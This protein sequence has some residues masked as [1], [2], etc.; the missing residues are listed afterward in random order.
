MLTRRNLFKFAATVGLSAL[1]L[2]SSRSAHAALSEVRQDH[3]PV[4]DGSSSERERLLLDI[5]WLEN[6]KDDLDCV[7]V[8]AYVASAFS[9]PCSAEINLIRGSSHC[10]FCREAGF[11]VG[12]ESFGCM[13]CE[14]EGSA[15][16]YYARAEG[17][18]H[19]VA[20][21][22]LD[23]LLEDG[24]LKGRRRENEHA[25]SMLLEAEQ[26][27]HELLC[28]SPEGEMARTCLLEQGVSQATIER[29]RLGYAPP[30]P[31]DA[32]SRHLVAAGY[33]I[34]K[35]LQ[36]SYVNDEGE[37]TL[38][39][40]YGG[41]YLLIPIGD[42]AGR[43]WGFMK[44]SLTSGQDSLHAGWTQDTLAVSE[45][46]LRRLIF[47]APAWPQD[48]ARHKRLLIADTPWEVVALHN[49][50]IENVVYLS[51][52]APDPVRLRTLLSVGRDFV[53]CVDLK[54]QRPA[55]ALRAI[56]R[57]EREARLLRVMSVP[58]R[59][60]VLKLLKTSGPQAVREAMSQAIPFHQWLE[61]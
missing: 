57:L 19:E 55:T 6:L 1:A 5:E 36:T 16:E 43:R 30:E 50:G 54:G 2:R 53:C 33:V 45:R 61:G 7:E 13:W 18:P 52:G 20:A 14:A 15:I 48:F 24:G 32:L 41:G 12:P 56:E 59:G 28:E 38:V 8:V 17:L 58:S 23:A 37:E 51:D 3:E 49:A 40:R 27:Y 29:F 39:D 42:Q 22:R 60:S 26:F 46:R 10:P 21:A 34:P 44:H 4:S 47:P 31:S 11:R 25:Y 35:L 9:M